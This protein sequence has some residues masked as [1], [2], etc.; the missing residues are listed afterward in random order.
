MFSDDDAVVLS[1]GSI[2]CALEL[3]KQEAVSEAEYRLRGDF[4]EDLLGSGT[5]S[6][7]SLIA[8]ARHL[9]YDLQQSYAVFAVNP[10]Y[11]ELAPSGGSSEKLV[12]EIGGYL[13][14]RH[15]HG[16]LA[17][18][19]RT[20]ALFVVVDV[21]TD[22]AAVQRIAADLRDYLSERAD[23]PASIGI[24][25]YHPGVIGLRR[26]Y[27]EAEQASQIG[28][29]FFGPAQVTA[30]ADLGVYRLLYAFR[31]SK[32]LGDFCR[33]T[34]APLIDYDAKNGTALIETL[35]TYFRCDANLR[36]AADALYL[37]RNSLA[38][39]LRRIA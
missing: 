26:S 12:R 27:Q 2:V 16:W 10:E 22:S 23:L 18:R 38:Y 36:I 9:G 28:R 25:S 15:L 8:R 7:E 14:G 24:G 32:E 39:R 35:D 5:A 31:Q 20:V 30:F 37:H 1:R 21:P 6:P 34:L 11:P 3:A 33:E 29:E 13:S 19:Q 17:P 4:F